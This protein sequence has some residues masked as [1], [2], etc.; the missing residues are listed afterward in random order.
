MLIVIADGKLTGSI[1]IANSPC[2]ASG[3]VAG[4]VDLGSVSFGS[5]EAG[6]EIQY[7]GTI[8]ADGTSMQGTYADGAACGNDTGNWSAKRQ[9]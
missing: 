3:N 2:V 4:V 1:D 5:V 7:Q 8:S 9:H 6:N